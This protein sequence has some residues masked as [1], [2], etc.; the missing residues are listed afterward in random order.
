MTR[1]AI[2]MLTLCTAAASAHAQTKPVAEL[3]RCTQR[4]G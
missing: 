1:I 3:T 2:A 4:T